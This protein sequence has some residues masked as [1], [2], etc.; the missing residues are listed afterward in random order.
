M[1][2]MGGGGEVDQQEGS[3]G[4]QYAEARQDKALPTR[5]PRSRASDCVPTLPSRGPVGGLV[6]VTL[7][8][9]G[10]KSCQ[11]C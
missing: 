6:E 3:E 2:A 10:A 5:E 1:E 9:A 7:T 8:S 11:V 4:G